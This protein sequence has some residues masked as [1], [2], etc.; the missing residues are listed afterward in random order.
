M[1][2]H[3]RLSKLASCWICSLLNKYENTHKY[4]DLSTLAILPVLIAT[5]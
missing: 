2:L 5:R 4:G 1:H 3:Y